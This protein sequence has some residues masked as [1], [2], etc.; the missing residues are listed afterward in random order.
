MKRKRYRVM[1]IAMIT[2]AAMAVTS[3]A[4]TFPDIQQKHSW[5]EPYIEDMVQRGLI[6]GYTDGTFKPDNPISKLEAIILA[7]R[8]L[9][10]TYDENKEFVDAAFVTFED[11]LADFDIQYKTEAAYLLYWGALRITELPAYIGDDVKNT[12]MTRHEVA[13]LLTKIMGGEAEAQGNP[14][15][16]L[17]Y[18]DVADIPPLQRHMFN[19]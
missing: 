1:F 6:K 8:I 5:A 11:E 4:G 7:S 13:K 2:F 3:V 15:V 9:G 19:I 17:D 16:I 18:A 10:V 12:A 14:I